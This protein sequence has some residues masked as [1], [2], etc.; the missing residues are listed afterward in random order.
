MWEFP[1]Y[2]NNWQ[3][4]RELTLKRDGYKCRQCG[5]TSN[6]EVCHI[7]SLSRGGS[8]ILDNLIT[9]CHQCHAKDY[10]HEHHK[11]NKYKGK[12]LL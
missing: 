9:K 3:E 4:L 12:V 7:I 11:F 8:S 10:K 6:L 1:K 2:P 5:A